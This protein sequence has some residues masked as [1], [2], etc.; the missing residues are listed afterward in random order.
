MRIENI[1]GESIAE[2]DKD[3]DEDDEDDEDDEESGAVGELGDSN[4]FGFLGR[5]LH[6]KASSSKNKAVCRN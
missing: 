4:R 1:F 5:D 2:I 3:E 6:N